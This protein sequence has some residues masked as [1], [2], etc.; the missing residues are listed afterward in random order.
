MKGVLKASRSLM[1]GKP[2]DALVGKTVQ[3]GNYTV[4]VE[5]KLGEGG[6]ASI[7]RVLNRGD[8]QRFALK[9]FRIQGDLQRYESV[10]QEALLMR[11]LKADPNIVTLYA[12][13]FGGP[14]RAPSD[15]FFLMQLC[16]GNLVE[17]LEQRHATMTE[18]DI[19]SIMLQVAKGV[20]YMHTLPEPIAHRCDIHQQ[21]RPLDMYAAK[22]SPTPRSSR[23]CEFIAFST[24][25]DT[26]AH[27]CA[28]PSVT[29]THDAQQGPCSHLPL[30]APVRSG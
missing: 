22:S 11:K 5:A 1:G 21:R 28:V 15:G 7:Y 20:R 9:H 26:P 2:A 24:A 18:K 8:Q 13:S 14:E 17:T 12:A 4:L 30:G 25:T 19:L 3:V 27:P 29:S 16:T 23:M 6:F 10:K